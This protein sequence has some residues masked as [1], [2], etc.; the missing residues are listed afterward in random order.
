MKTADEFPGSYS[1]LIQPR[2]PP[3]AAHIRGPAPSSS[4]TSLRRASSPNRVRPAPSRAAFAP[5]FLTQADLL[6]SI[7]PALTVRSDTFVIRAYGDVQ[8][9]AT[10]T[11]EG[12]AWCEAVVQR[13]PD[14][15]DSSVNPCTAPQPNSP[16]EI[17]GRRFKII[18][19][20]WL[21]LS[22]I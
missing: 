7:G 15:I 18:S 4:R 5:G 19:L 11:I 12:K 16:S 6:N 3:P 13:F 10:S 14:Y 9:P 21:G 22:D 20:R 17:L 2:R 1:R 8:N